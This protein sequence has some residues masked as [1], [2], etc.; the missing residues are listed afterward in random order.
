MIKHDHEITEIFLQKEKS[1][2]AFLDHISHFEIKRKNTLLTS[3][4]RVAFFEKNIASFSQKEKNY[5]KEK[6]FIIVIFSKKK[7]IKIFKTKRLFLFIIVCYSKILNTI[8]FFREIKKRN[9]LTLKNFYHIFQNI[10]VAR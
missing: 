7:E 3:S 8:Q 10:I 4:Q 1:K 2:V 5:Q 9:R 6:Q